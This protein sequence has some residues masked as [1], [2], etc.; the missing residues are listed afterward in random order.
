MFD[1]NKNNNN[2]KETKRQLMQQSQGL[3]TVHG[4]TTHTYYT[5]ENERDETQTMWYTIV[6]FLGGENKQTKSVTSSSM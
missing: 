1:T 4:H 5:N 2:N 6:C 3:K